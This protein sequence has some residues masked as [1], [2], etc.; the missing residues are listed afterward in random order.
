MAGGDQASSVLNLRIT[1]YELR[2]HSISSINC[3]TPAA[4]E[5]LE[6]GV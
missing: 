3:L 4:Q 5:P 1:H 6:R 2:I